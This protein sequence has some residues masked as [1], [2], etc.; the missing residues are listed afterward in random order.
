MNRTAK[1]IPGVCLTGF[2]RSQEAYWCQK[3]L[4]T[5]LLLLKTSATIIKYMHSVWQVIL[6]G[7]VCDITNIVPSLLFCAFHS[8][9]PMATY[10]KQFLVTKPLP[11]HL[12][13]GKIVH[14]LY[15][16]INARGRGFSKCIDPRTRLSRC[17]WRVHNMSL[18]SL[19]S[20]DP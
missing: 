19:S 12:E 4:G 7:S 15:F 3:L 11:R 9:R 1:H 18:F 17:Y 13:C 5:T 6:Y 20:L 8:I 2:Q 16:R 14:Y 10:H